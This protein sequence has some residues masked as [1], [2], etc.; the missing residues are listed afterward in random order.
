MLERFAG[1]WCVVSH[2]VEVQ[3]VRHDPS[4]GSCLC[5][6]LSVHTVCFPCDRG[7]RCYML[8]HVAL[9]LPAVSV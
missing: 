3:L 4:L 2:M 5:V 8:I 6:G 1:L 7:T 9:V